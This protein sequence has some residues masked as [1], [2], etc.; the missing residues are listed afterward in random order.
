MGSD[1]GRAGQRPGGTAPRSAGRRRRQVRALVLLAG[2]CALG[3]GVAVGL[4][5]NPAEGERGTGATPPSRT[6]GSGASAGSGTSGLSAPGRT[7]DG[8]TVRLA[9]GG[10]VHFEGSSAAALTTGLPTVR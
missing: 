1:A 10:D 4:S 7:T 8:R 6:S 3:V 5:E 9:F 2:V